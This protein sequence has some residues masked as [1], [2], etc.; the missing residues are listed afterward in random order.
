MAFTTSAT[1]GVASKQQQQQQQQ[2]QEEMERRRTSSTSLEM[3]R[4]INLFTRP[5]GKKKRNTSDNPA[6]DMVTYFGKPKSVQR[7]AELGSKVLVSGLRTFEPAY[8]L[9]HSPEE[10]V[11]EFD[12][13]TAMVEN[14]EAARKT[15]ISRTA[16]YSGL[17][18][19][20][21]FLEFQEGETLLPTVEQLKEGAFSTWLAHV[22]LDD[23]NRQE[24]I[25]KV[26]KIADLAL[27]ASDTLRN[28]AVLVSHGGLLKVED[29][30]EMMDR[31]GAV[32]EKLGYSVVIVPRLS[33]APGNYYPYMV[34]KLGNEDDDKFMLDYRER[35]SGEE[36]CRLVTDVL[37]LETGRGGTMV[38]R[39]LDTFELIDAQFIDAMRE[40]G[41]SRS[42]EM[43][44]LLDQGIKRFMVA[45]VAYESNYEQKDQ[46]F[47]QVEEFE[48][49][50]KVPEPN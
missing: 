48:K 36:A 42:Q 44:Y 9:L 15:M 21:Q 25:Q 37:S 43:N 22:P 3:G 10:K 34:E 7:R 47:S 29:T 16:R 5:E 1:F 38:M 46:L 27:A 24:L 23:D 2:Q 33:N 8:S 30:N 6:E 45:K 28:V 13:V 32:S 19:V 14:E 4:R 11:F 39:E 12:S 26:Y 50:G 49:T 17:L 41:Y 35:M 40:A 20:L 18:D 31:F